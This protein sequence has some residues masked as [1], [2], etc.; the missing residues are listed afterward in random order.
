MLPS[1]GRGHGECEAS[2]CH[3]SRSVPEPPAVT[4]RRWD[5]GRSWPWSPVGRGPQHPVQ[6]LISESGPRSTRL[7]CLFSKDPRD[8]FFLIQCQEKNFFFSLDNCVSLTSSETKMHADVGVS[9]STLAARKCPAKLHARSFQLRF[10][11]LSPIATLCLYALPS[12]FSFWFGF[13]VVGLF[14]LLKMPWLFKN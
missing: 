9:L 7:L 13:M 3:P 10:P 12:T 14:S 2:Q 4:E 11:V 1:G 5:P 8:E 6:P